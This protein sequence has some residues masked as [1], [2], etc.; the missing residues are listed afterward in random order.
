MHKD[1]W[2]I[3]NSEISDS[4]IGVTLPSMTSR[5]PTPSIKDGRHPTPPPPATSIDSVT[6]SVT[7]WRDSQRSRSREGSVTF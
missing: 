3:E 5:S 4:S 2:F 1:E 7:A 6:H